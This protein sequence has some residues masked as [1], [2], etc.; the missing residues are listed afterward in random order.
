M[1]AAK[2]MGRR[3]FA[4]AA[5]GI[6]TALKMAHAPGLNRCAVPTPPA[7]GVSGMSLSASEAGR[8][9]FM[10]KVWSAVR[11]GTQSHQEYE[12]IRNVRRSM[13]GGLDPDLSVLNSMSLA[14]RVQI[15]LEREIRARDQERSIRHRIITG[16]GGNPKEFE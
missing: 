6:P 4:R 3:L 1:S 14:R 15:Q 12:S 5:V 16:L 13:M 2:A 8:Q 10:Q 9:T 7:M 11:S